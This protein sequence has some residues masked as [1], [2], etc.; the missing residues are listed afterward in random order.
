MFPGIAMKT[1]R[2]MEANLAH[3]LRHRYMAVMVRFTTRSLFFIPKEKALVA[4]G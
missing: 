1:Y 3:S 2:R 4:T